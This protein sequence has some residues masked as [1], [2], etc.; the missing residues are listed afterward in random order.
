[1]MMD[2]KPFLTVMIPV[3]NGMDYVAESIRSALDQPCRDLEVLVLDDGSQDD[4]LTICQNLAEEDSRV[5][6][7]THTNV[8]LG[9]N[10]NDGFTYVHGTWLV[11]LDHDDVMAPG[12]YSEQT[13][14]VLQKCLSQGIEMVVNTRARADE[15]LEHV[16]MDLLG[17]RGV[18]PTHSPESWMLPYELATNWYSVDLIETNHLRFA[19]TRPEM[20]SIFR[21]QCAY[22]A[23]K[24]VFC[25]RAFIEIRRESE[26]QITRTWNIA[27]VAAV[28]WRNYATMPA[29]HEEHGSD[30]Y[31][32]AKAWETLDEVIREFFVCAVRNHMDMPRI[33]AVLE[34]N[35][36]NKSMCQPHDG[37]R[38]AIN[39]MLRFFGTNRLMAL[40]STVLVDLIL[41]RI[42]GQFRGSLGE[43]KLLTDD[44]MCRIARDYPQHLL[45][46]LEE[47]ES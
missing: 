7:V 34:E 38:S 32:V 37:Y 5:H 25:D 33:H 24:I 39:R 14:A 43:S 15:H 42:T 27:R 26:G 17:L 40:R 8:G 23:R 18:F 30:A 20:E 3:Y 1:M 44:E 35:G 47:A 22:L 29:W 6:V 46:V 9:A 13:K 12:V 11:F 2:N 16:R 10:R 31:A 21:H 4:T 19:E 41:R 45:S 28:R 36:V